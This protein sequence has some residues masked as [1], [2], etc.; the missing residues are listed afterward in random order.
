MGAWRRGARRPLGL[1]AWAVPEQRLPPLNIDAVNLRLPTRPPP[2]PP[3]AVA[4]AAAVAV[5]AAA[6]DEPLTL[7]LNAATLPESICS[8]ARSQSRQDR[9]RRHGACR[10]LETRRNAQGHV[11]VG[12][13]LE[14]APAANPASRM[15][16]WPAAN[17][18]CSHHRACASPRRACARSGARS[19]RRRPPT[20]C[21]AILG[22]AG[23]DSAGVA[24]GGGRT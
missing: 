21:P 9:R 5:V 11:F 23:G 14:T 4:A 17:R 18:P 7:R 12:V 15:R 24:P 3:P 13:L 1:P 6:S 19:G 8:A 22:T 10:M 2:S 16:T 20:P